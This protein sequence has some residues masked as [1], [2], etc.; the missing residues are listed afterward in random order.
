MLLLTFFLLLQL[1]SKSYLV[2]PIFQLV[3]QEGFVE[4]RLERRCGR[5]VYYEGSD[6]PGSACVCVYVCAYVRYSVFLPSE[7]L[8]FSLAVCFSS[9][10]MCTYVHAVY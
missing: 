4:P 9:T 3:L 10:L 7:L 1:Q 2:G 5:Q 6:S 8:L